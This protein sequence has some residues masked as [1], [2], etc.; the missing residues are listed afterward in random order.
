MVGVAGPG[1]GAGPIVTGMTVESAARVPPEPEPEPGPRRFLRPGL[2]VVTGSRV[3]VVD[4]VQP[5]ALVVDA[6]EIG[7]VGLVGWPQAPPGPAPEQRVVLPAEDALWVQ[8]HDGPVVRVEAT[9]GVLGRYVSDTVLGASS[10]HGAWCAPEPRSQ[11]IAATPDAPPSDYRTSTRLRLVRRDETTRTVHVDAPVSSLR[12]VHGDLFVE[13]ETGAWTRTSLGTPTSWDLEPETTWLRLPAAADVPDR[14]GASTHGSSAPPPDD[15]PGWRYH[16]LPDPRDLMTEDDEE[17][18]RPHARTTGL[19]WF[20]GADR[21]GTTRPD[22]LFA[23]AYAAGT[24]QERWRVALG[25]GSVAAVTAT[26]DHVWVAVRRGPA[27]SYRPSSPTAVVRVDARDGQV[28]T[29]V[30]PDSV[31]IAAHGWPLGPPPVDA[32]DY[33]AF[34][35]RH[36]E[37]LDAYWTDEHGHVHPLTEGL[38]DARVDVVG[39]WPGTT[40]HVT[41]R[42]ARR[43]GVRLRRVVAL[44]DDLGRPEE[45]TYADI[46]MME[47]LDTGRV[48]DAPLPG[49]DHLDF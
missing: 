46:H 43:P 45:P 39:A 35:R 41:F 37:G 16:H 13:V 4:R 30:E 21:A 10:A 3:W 32:A 40:L 49:A 8:Q 7:P 12:G 28:E 42:W 27:D 6:V 31:E 25:D 47:D 33:T 2:L 11:D 34:W 26:D 14:L 48:P 15:G 23:V 19:D 1:S 5:V 24:S 9:G 22:R 20:V 36:L 44:F 18:V 38:S 17:E 29:V